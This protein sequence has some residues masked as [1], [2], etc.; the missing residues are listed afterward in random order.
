MFS[1]CFFKHPPQ[2]PAIFIAG[3]IL[4]FVMSVFRPSALLS[5]VRAFIS[6]LFSVSN[7]PPSLNVKDT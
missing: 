2:F 6:V 1:K 5:I 3:A 7:P 4:V